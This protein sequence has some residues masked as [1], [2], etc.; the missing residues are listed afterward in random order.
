M[1]KDV[2]GNI[3]SHNYIQFFHTD[4]K[5]LFSLCCVNF[6]PFSG[7]VWQRLILYQVRKRGRVFLV[8]T[9][10]GRISHYLSG[11]FYIK[12]LRRNLFDCGFV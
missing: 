7:A 2:S 11:L 5:L 3:S 4:E 1:L 6:I 12:F 8:E 10:D 9:L